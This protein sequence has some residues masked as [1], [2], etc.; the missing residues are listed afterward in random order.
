MNQRFPKEYCGKNHRDFCKSFQ[1]DLLQTGI[2]L[3]KFPEGFLFFMHME[4]KGPKMTAKVPFMQPLLKPILSFAIIKGTTKSV[5]SHTRYAA[6]EK[7]D[8]G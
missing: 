3:D 2:F 8:Y 4:R 1:E 7:N 6:M 5:G